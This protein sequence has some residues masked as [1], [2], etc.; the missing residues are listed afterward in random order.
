MARHDRAYGV[1]HSSKHTGGNKRRKGEKLSAS[2]RRRGVSG[3]RAK[4]E[5]RES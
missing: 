2:D 3:Y 1:Y 5:K 4:V